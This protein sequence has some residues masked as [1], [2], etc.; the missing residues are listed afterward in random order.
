MCSGVLCQEVV[1]S[2]MPE[3]TTPADNLHQTV[4][5]LCLPRSTLREAGIDPVLGQ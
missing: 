1:A 2:T 3:S 4:A 5:D